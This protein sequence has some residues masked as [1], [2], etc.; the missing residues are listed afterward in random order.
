MR[1]VSLPHK[2]DNVAPRL[3]M[4]AS[5]ELRALYISSPHCSPV[6]PVSIKG[7]FQKGNS[8]PEPSSTV[9]LPTVLGAP[10]RPEQPA[11]I[12]ERSDT[13]SSTSRT[14]PPRDGAFTLIGHAGEAPG[15]RGRH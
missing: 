6:C 1:W 8:D 2:N 5:K 11:D 10:H 14:L 7:N 4:H 15:P 3:S 13:E 12:M 9:Q